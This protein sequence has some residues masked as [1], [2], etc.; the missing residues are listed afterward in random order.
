MTSSSVLSVR[1][2]AA[3]KERLDKLAVATKRSKSF[4]AAEA[5]EE[6]IAV[7]EW[8]IAGIERAIASADAGELIDHEEVRAWVDSFD[9]DDE[10]PIPKP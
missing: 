10:L 2:D 8:Q 6:F 7:Q 3:T 9:T 4:L 5:I 1:I